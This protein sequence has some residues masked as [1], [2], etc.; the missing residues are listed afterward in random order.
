MKVLIKASAE[1]CM[2]CAHC[3]E[4]ATPPSEE[5]IKCQ[6]DPA[7]IGEVVQFLMD[8]GTAYAVVL[9]KDEFWLTDIVNLR[10]IK[11]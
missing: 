3:P 6:N 9:I 10:L 8:N 4:D 1:I 11:E 5:C 7:N 2:T